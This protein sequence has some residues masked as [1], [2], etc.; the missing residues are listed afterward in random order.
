MKNARVLA[1]AL[2]SVPAV[3]SPISQ[4]P[5]PPQE[6][7]AETKKELTGEIS[8]EEFKRLHE[9]KKEAAP[10]RK[11]T[12]VDVS[13]TRAYLSLPEGAKTPIPGIVV[14]HEWWGLN[15]HVMHWADRLAADGY[16]ALAIDLYGGMVATTPDEAMAAMK[17]VDEKKAVETLLAAHRFLREDARIR[18]EKRGV[19][20][21]CFGGKM[22]LKLALAAPDLDAAVMYYGHPVVDPKEL[23]PLRAPLLGL[24]GSKDKSIPPSVVEQ[25]DE[26]LTA[27]EK[28]HEI[29]SYEAEHAFANP[30]GARYDEEHAAAAWAMVRAFL[31]KH[32]EQVGGIPKEPK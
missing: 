27:A 13:G 25:F 3:A 11:G 7:P 8:E 15:D 16:A 23:E 18:A 30:S 9:L 21:W 29:L 24:F 28:E 17:K 1:F 14:I 5:K 6:K 20:G 19:I 31:A 22:S 12:M 32:L 4:E 2:M 10:P 26:A